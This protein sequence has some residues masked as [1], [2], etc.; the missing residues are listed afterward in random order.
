MDGDQ[1]NQCTLVLGYSSR[2]VI[3]RL[4]LSLEIENLP[5]DRSSSCGDKRVREEVEFFP[6]F[7]SSRKIS[8]RGKLTKIE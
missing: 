6:G 8:R 2:N 4:Y 3:D 7:L 5:P 1:R